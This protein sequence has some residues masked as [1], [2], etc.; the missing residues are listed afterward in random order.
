MKRPFSSSGF[1]Q[2][3]CIIEQLKGNLLY[4]ASPSN[5]ISSKTIQANEVTLLRFQNL[6]NSTL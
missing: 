1:G 3:L 5:L 6:E 4:N 2:A